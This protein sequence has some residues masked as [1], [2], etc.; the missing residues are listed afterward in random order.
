M[1]T[2]IA[3]LILLGLSLT[4]LNS[5]RADI[6]E[7]KI[8]EQSW[9]EQ[10]E[11]LKS[12]TSAKVRDEVQQQLIELYGKAGIQIRA[13]EIDFKV[14][15]VDRGVAIGIELSPIQVSTST[16][17][18]TFNVRDALLAFEIITHS[19]PF[20]NSIGEVSAVD[21][22]LFVDRFTQTSLKWENELFNSKT[23]VRIADLEADVHVPP[24]RRIAIQ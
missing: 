21:C 1:R 17:K 22:G 20:T 23:K 18:D 3:R 16:R 11:L 2:G 10:R 9:T 7:R 15:I 4:A 12:W 6:D 5:A 8:C 24:V 13:S 19:L 14:N